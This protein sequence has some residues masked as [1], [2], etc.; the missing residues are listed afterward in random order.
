MKN[1]RRCKDQEQPIKWLLMPLIAALLLNAILAETLLAKAS[2]LQQPLQGEVSEQ[3]VSN[4]ANQN[5]LT[6][7]A[8]GQPLIPVAVPETAHGAQAA[9]IP[10]SNLTGAVVQTQKDG[11]SPVTYEASITDGKIWQEGFWP[12]SFCSTRAG[13]VLSPELLAWWQWHHNLAQEVCRVLEP[14]Y[15][16]VINR[17]H[18]LDTLAP[19]T[20]RTLDGI[21][22][23][24]WQKKW[25]WGS[26]NPLM[27]TFILEVTPDNQVRVEDIAYVGITEYKNK[28]ID[29]NSRDWAF[30]CWAQQLWRGA[31]LRLNDIHVVNYPPPCF[32]NSQI[33]RS[34]SNAVRIHVSQLCY[35]VPSG[36]DT[37]YVH[38]I[39]FLCL[40]NLSLSEPPVR[41]N[42]AAPAGYP[43]FADKIYH[44]PP[45][46]QT[47]EYQRLARRLFPARA[48]NGDPFVD[49]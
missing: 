29:R 39:N 22:G 11:L 4:P 3:S 8:Q 36:N 49:W 17:A 15:D 13:G 41:F 2:D 6:L 38:D 47:P 27:P 44:V 35:P 12:P 16:T 21:F 18:E 34:Y 46:L 7:P 5:G 42:I 1:T 30:R 10:T 23:G 48:K 25:G 32:V 14:T 26:P 28:P 19:S 20:Y 45:A 9:M 24:T 40:E 31:I 33:G 43:T 37:R